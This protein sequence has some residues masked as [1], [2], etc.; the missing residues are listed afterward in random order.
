VIKNYV[1]MLFKS[2]QQNTVQKLFSFL[3]EYIHTILSTVASLVLQIYTKKKIKFH[4]QKTISATRQNSFRT[5]QRNRWIHDNYIQGNSHSFHRHIVNVNA[6]HI[7]SQ[8]RFIS[9]SFVMKS[10]KNI[11]GFQTTSK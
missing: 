1:K 6:K 10:E 9:T 7:C 8:T 5:A 4:H 2:V 11:N 3:N